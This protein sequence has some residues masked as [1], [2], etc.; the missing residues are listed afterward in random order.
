MTCRSTTGAEAAYLGV[1]LAGVVIVLAFLV[2]RS[3]RAIIIG[4]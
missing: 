2:P 1:I 4:R 3:L